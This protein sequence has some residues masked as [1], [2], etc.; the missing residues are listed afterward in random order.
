MKGQPAIFLDRDG[1]LIEDRG[2]LASPTQVVFFPN[3]V[4]ALR[5]L[6][7][8]F[9]LFI[10]TH[11]PG[12]ARGQVTPAEVDGVNKAVTNHL[13]AAGIMIRDVYCCP[14]ERTDGCECIKPKPYYPYRA[15]N[16]YG[17]DL[18]SSFSVGD[19]PHDVDL[20]RNCGATGIYV[21]TGHGQK[22][23]KELTP[24]TIITANIYDAAH[25]I[26][27]R[28]RTVYSKEATR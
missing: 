23:Q 8:H 22:H 21:L 16:A 17:L 11:Q 7:P 18:L 15:A 25:Y 19:H 3:T 24:D 28:Y 27:D 2:D 9:L 10:V 4:D 26:L 12:I 5:V 20:G 13:V 6:A 14:H 1:T